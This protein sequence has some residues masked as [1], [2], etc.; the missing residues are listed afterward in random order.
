MSDEKPAPCPFCGGE[1]IRVYEYNNDPDAFCQCR[2]CS[3][4]GPYGS[5]RE[6]AIAAWNRRVA[7]RELSDAEIL[8]LAAQKFPSSIRHEPDFDYQDVIAFARAVLAAGGRQ[9][10]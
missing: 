4:D 8:N 9:H 3:S 1:D 5:G 10:G 2:D 6:A 7:Q